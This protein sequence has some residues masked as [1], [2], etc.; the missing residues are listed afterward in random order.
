MIEIQE[1]RT[2]LYLLSDALKRQDGLD[3]Y[4]L[5]VLNIVNRP[6]SDIAFLCAKTSKGER[7]FVLKQIAH[8]PEN[9]SITTSQNQAIVEYD[10]LNHLYPKFLPDSLCHVPRPIIAIPEYEAYIMEFVE[11]HLLGDLFGGCKYFAPKKA[12]NDLKEYYYLCGLWLKKF[13]ENTGVQNAGI[14][15][16]SY[17][18]ERCEF[19]LNLI[20]ESNNS[21]C[22]IDLKNH[23]MSFIYKQLELVSENDV[24]V[25][26][27][28]GDFGSWNILAG[29]NGITVF[30]FMGYKHDLFPIDLLQMLM[31][32]EN[33]K[34][35]LFFSTDRVEAL[36]LMFLQGYG[37]VPHISQPV[38]KICET[39][40][41]VCSLYSSLFVPANNIRRG[42][43]RQLTFKANLAWLMEEDKELLWPV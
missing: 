43:E 18:I 1:L 9:S 6:Y 23:V 29:L 28:H 12:F 14:D 31:N 21:R 35:F 10:V 30:D 8:H 42:I 39:F 17:T 36:R 38:L 13:Q 26:G 40:H 7:K 25:T 37:E 3:V 33:E 15:A 41:R 22:P 11:G 24:L 34:L 16:F 2:K 32:L 20:E 27:R 4:S 19:R 5:D